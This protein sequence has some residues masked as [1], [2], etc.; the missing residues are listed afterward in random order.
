MGRDPSRRENH[1][2][3]YKYI[4]SG[5]WFCLSLDRMQHRPSSRKVRKLPD[6][7][8][9]SGPSHPAALSTDARLSTRPGID[10]E[11]FDAAL[12]PPWRGPA[13]LSPGAGPLHGRRRGGGAPGDGGRRAGEEEEEGEEGER[14][15]KGVYFLLVTVN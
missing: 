6:Q 2:P 11:V 1:A 15:I 4:R 3:R 8:T 10:E 12:R 5:L 14:I 9:Y 7:I 13:F